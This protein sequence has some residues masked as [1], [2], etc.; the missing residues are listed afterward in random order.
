MTKKEFDKVLTQYVSEVVE[1]RIYQYSD[2]DFD[3]IFE[4]IIEDVL[5][6]AVCI[7]VERGMAENNRT[8]GVYDLCDENEERLKLDGTWG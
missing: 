8:N 3:Y 2:K 6:D 4:D 7:G 1:E 5:N